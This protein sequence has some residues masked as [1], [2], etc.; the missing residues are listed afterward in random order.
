MLNEVFIAGSIQTALREI[1]AK[2]TE[3]LFSFRFRVPKSS[4]GSDSIV[5]VL[6]DQELVEML[7]TIGL[8]E[9]ISIAGRLQSRF[10]RNGNAGASITEVKVEDLILIN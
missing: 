3:G 2:G 8:G 5:C 1:P 4:G 6:D 7:G 10:F 9:E